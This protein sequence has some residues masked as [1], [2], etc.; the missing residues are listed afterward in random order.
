MGSD[1]NKARYDLF[2]S[3]VDSYV[4]AFLWPRYVWAPP[5]VN[6]ALMAH[7]IDKHTST[8]PRHTDKQ[9]DGLESG[10]GHIMPRH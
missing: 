10:K 5:S 9:A 1:L 2:P 7:C 8:G 6:G 3:I 4:I